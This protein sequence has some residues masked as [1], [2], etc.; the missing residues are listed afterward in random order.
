MP[1]TRPSANT[2]RT[3]RFLA[4]LTLIVIAAGLSS[5][6][7]S[8]R[9]QNSRDKAVQ[10]PSASPSPSP[11]P[12]LKPE[13]ETII[14]IKG[15]SVE[16][17]F[18]EGIYKPTDQYECA[19]C[20]FKLL[21]VGP[22]AGPLTPCHFINQNSTVTIHAGGGRKDIKIRRANGIK[23]DFNGREYGPDTT[24]TKK[25]YNSRNNIQSVNVT[26]VPLNCQCPTTGLCKIQV[27]TTTQ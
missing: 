23:I 26:P 1:S 18:D 21:E 6:C 16:L 10:Q 12:S 3:A 11:L 13:G 15:G 22:L 19:T 20:N 17:I 27:T 5:N 4:L 7:S 25:H 2:T 8:D 9:N 14:V 24:G